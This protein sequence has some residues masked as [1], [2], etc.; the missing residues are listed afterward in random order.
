M[1]WSKGL[2]VILSYDQKRRNLVLF[3]VEGTRLG[4]YTTVPI[5][6]NLR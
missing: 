4:L 1:H 2:Y 5:P 3:E 6:E